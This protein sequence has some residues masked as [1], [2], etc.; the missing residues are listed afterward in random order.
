VKG[1]FVAGS[2]SFVS[3]IARLTPHFPMLPLPIV[4]DVQ[5]TVY[6]IVTFSGLLPSV[7]H[8]HLQ[9][10]QVWPRKYATGGLQIGQGIPHPIVSNAFKNEWNHEKLR[11]NYTRQDN[12]SFVLLQVID[13]AE[14]YVS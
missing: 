3:H 4:S 5:H 7:A 9:Q 2:D 6:R 12:W 14:P 8:L 11:M 10:M 1:V 13:S